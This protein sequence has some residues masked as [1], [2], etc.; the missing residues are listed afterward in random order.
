MPAE[1]AEQGFRLAEDCLSVIYQYDKD[2][3]EVNIA[4][5]LQAVSD[6][7]LGV[8]DIH[9]QQSSL[10]EIFVDLVGESV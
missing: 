3:L 10:E 6:A 2:G 4:G 9:T 1:L 5:L 8:K 7:G